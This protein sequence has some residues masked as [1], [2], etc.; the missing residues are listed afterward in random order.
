MEISPEPTPSEREA[1]EVA[2]QRLL[3]DDVVPTPYASAW[4]EAGIRE[5]A[6]AD[7]PYATARPRS[8]PGAT[9]A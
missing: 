9:R 1:L 5:N 2:L 7:E 3:A 6:G 4:R 8:R